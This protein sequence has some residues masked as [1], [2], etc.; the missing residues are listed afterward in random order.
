MGNQEVRKAIWALQD[1]EK[2]KSFL[3]FLKL[4]SELDWKAM[5]IMVGSGM[6]DR[7]GVENHENR[8]QEQAIELC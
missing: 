8:H 7:I 2:L 1:Y 4:D 3:A 5:H 6:I